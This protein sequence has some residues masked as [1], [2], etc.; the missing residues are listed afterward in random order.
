MYWYGMALG[1]TSASTAVDVQAGDMEL[2]R[3]ARDRRLFAT[4]QVRIVTSD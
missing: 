2:A 3:R 4:D 1:Q